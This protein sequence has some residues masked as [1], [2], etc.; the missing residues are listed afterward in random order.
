MAEQ[1]LQEAKAFLKTARSALQ[2]GDSEEANRL[3]RLAIQQAPNWELPWLFLAATSEPAQGL[4]FVARALEI[5]PASKPARKAIRWIIRKLPANNRRQAIDRLCIPENL[6]VRITPLEDLT[7][8]RLFSFRLFASFLLCLSGLGIWIGYK[9]AD[10]QQS[11]VAS[12]PVPKA[13]LTPTPTN[14]PTNTPT[15]TITPTSTPTPTPTNTP[16]PAISP[17]PRP[18]VSFEYTLNP[19]ELADEGR[20]IDVDLGE[21]LVTAYD[22]ASPVV[23]FPVSTGTASHPTVTGQFRIWT[24]LRYDDMTGPGYYLPD[25]PYTM[26]FYKS[27][28]LHGTYWHH[29][30]GHPMSHGC[31]NLR[32]ENAKWLYE[33]ASV[34]TLVNVHP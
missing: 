33:F 3:A 22:G 15:P 30:F 17:T 26:Y 9:P 14:T 27:Y 16:T 23:S 6:K 29:N 7:R 4:N 28:A 8:R 25:V 11:I 34:G 24:K 1:G 21:Q 12:A 5:N 20:W 13:S 32:T 31:I 19:E 10:A 18:K 2:Q